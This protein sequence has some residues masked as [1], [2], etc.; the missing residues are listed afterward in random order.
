MKRLLPHA[1]LAVLL[2]GCDLRS[3]SVTDAQTSA[4]GTVLATNSPAVTGT[5]AVEGSGTNKATAIQA[6]KA[7]VLAED[8]APAQ[9][10]VPKPPPDLPVP[11]AEV[12]RLAQ[13]TL[14][15]SVLIDYVN[16]VKEPYTLNADQVI[17]LSDLGIAPP[18]VQAL[19]RHSAGP[20]P[21]AAPA[22]VT[23]AVAN[24]T[25]AVPASPEQD[26]G[27]TNAILM[28]Y[29]VSTAPGAPAGAP[30]LAAAP[31]PGVP[32]FQPP[33]GQVPVAVPQPPVEVD[34][35]QIY[36]S[37]S[38]YGSWVEDPDNGWCWQ[39]TVAVID[40]GWR[41]Y[42]NEGGW[43][44]T[45]AGW[46]WNSTYSW[47]WL[48]FHYGRW[49]LASSRGWVWV[50]DNVWGPAW[51]T[52][53][54]TDTLC[55]WA[56]LP[57]GA[58]WH[59]G[60][61]LV[62]HG[63]HVSAY[64]DFGLHESWYCA[65]PFGRFCDPWPRRYCLNRRDMPG[66][67]HGS[68]IV[69]DYRSIHDGPH[70]HE[71]EHFVNHGPGTKP[72]QQATRAEV[73]KY[74]IHD[75]PRPGG[76]TPLPSRPNSPGGERSITA[77][78]GDLPTT[79]GRPPSTV[80]ARQ[81]D[82][83]APDTTYGA[84]PARPAVPSSNL[85]ERGAGGIAGNGQPRTPSNP[86]PGG[87]PPAIQNG[88]RGVT[89]GEPANIYPSGGPARPTPATAGFAATGGSSLASR[90]T[91][92]AVSGPSGASSSGSTPGTG[93]ARPVVAGRPGGPQ[94]VNAGVQPPASSRPQPNAMGATTPVAPPRPIA[95]NEPPAAGASN[96]NVFQHNESGWARTSTTPRPLSRSDMVAGGYLD[97][98][99]GVAQPARPA[100]TIRVPNSSSSYGAANS[101]NNGGGDRPGFATPQP[102]ARYNPPAQNYSAPVAAPRPA[103][104]PAP[105][106]QRYSAPPPAAAPAP[107][108]SRGSSG[109]SQPA[110][111]PSGNNGGRHAN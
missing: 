81:T 78:R 45:D 58:R 94:G 83:Q 4:N 16:S 53:R 50:P 46:Y 77:Y 108:S 64:F 79:T 47:G 110:A 97:N 12:V 11:V 55:G 72:V 8:P 80:L 31:A 30:P 18:V 10:A 5:R 62:F 25:N 1:C 27:G 41:P 88:N 17:Y 28:N 102:A 89:R 68:R 87:E 37:L 20:A 105:P 13:H 75:T 38:P 85:A 19:L 43:V 14:G 90:P 24:D 21:A 84:G 74:N 101:F 111:R 32:A 107:S 67:Y 103:Y 52:W 104:T 23:L 100:P 59:S 26:P 92:A 95:R 7:A 93:V 44:W 91:G 71:R 56:P 65:V 57:P 36:T 54:T 70:G 82:R 86:R 66:F 34:N 73:V 33:P 96:P 40:T 9:I 60:V 63:A 35:S 48:P 49:T 15:E 98:S 106:V 22:P 109:T 69:N 42:L 3:A 76:P 51:V 29:L 61:G 39:P 2:A 6:P 99:G